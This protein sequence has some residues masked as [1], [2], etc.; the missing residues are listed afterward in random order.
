MEIKGQV[1]EGVQVCKGGSGVVMEEWRGAG[2]W[3]VYRCEEKGTI[4]A[5]QG[6]YICVYVL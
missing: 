4:C 3:Y 6:K 1:R 2:V 5:E